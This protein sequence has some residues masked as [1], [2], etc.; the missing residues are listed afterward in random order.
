[1]LTDSVK[2]IQTSPFYMTPA[3]P[4]GSGPD[5]VNAAAEIETSLSAHELL[6]FLHEIE[7]AAGRERLKRWAQ[8]S[9]DLDLISYER[10]VL[11]NVERHKEWVNLPFEEQKNRAPNELILPHPRVQDRAFMLVPLR[12]VAPDWTHPVTGLSINGLISNLPAQD[13]AELRKL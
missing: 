12:D 2:V 8:R 10:A 13:V 3:F 7:A 4:K 1:M 5:F 9:L 6:A 11:P